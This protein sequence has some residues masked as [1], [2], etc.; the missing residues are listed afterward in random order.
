MALLDKLEMDGEIGEEIDADPAPDQAAPKRRTRKPRTPSP[1]VKRP[2]TKTIGTMAKEVGNDIAT[3]L[4]MTSVVWGVRDQCC[5]PVLEAQAKPI[6]QAIAQI[7][8]RNPEL[9][10]KF[11]QAETG[12]FVMQCLA[13]GQALLPVGQAVFHNHVLRQGDTDQNADVTDLDTFPAFSGVHRA[14]TA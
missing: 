6:G 3:M 11:A 10:R 8:A 13:L 4:E 14:H 9:L 2:A 7:L 12:V 5:A 1:Q